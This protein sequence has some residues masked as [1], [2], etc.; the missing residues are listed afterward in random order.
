MYRR[1][2]L[3]LSFAAVALIGIQHSAQGQILRVNGS[4]TVSN[5]V[6]ITHE[7]E[8]EAL[9]GQ[10]LDVQSTGS[11]HGITA[12]VEGAADMAMIS[13]PLPAVVEGLNAETPGRIDARNLVAHEI[14]ANHVA[15]VIHPSNPVRRL[16]SDQ[17]YGILAGRITNW[18]EVGGLPMPIRIMVEAPGGGVRSVVEG[19]V[20]NHGDTFA[21]KAYVPYAP[22]IVQA[23]SENLDMFGI[24]S[25]AHVDGT[26]DP[27]SI[28]EDMVQRLSLVTIGPPSQRMVA[29]IEATRST[30]QRHH[31]NGS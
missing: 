1:L 4:S 16:T 13:A 28:Q 25:L 31:G 23:V 29:V 22:M 18:S 6:M 27:L 9:S 2:I 20:K 15:F 21:A 30:W 3:S 14:G 7:S 19:N 24:A 26:V 12:L 8:I 5:S 11:G 17:L 10:L